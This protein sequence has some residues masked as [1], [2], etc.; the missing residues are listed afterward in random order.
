MRWYWI[1]RYTEFVR[2]ERAT[3]VKNISLAEEHMH[4]HFKYFPVMPHSLVVEGVAQTGGLLISEYKN[5]QEKVVLAKIVKAIF[6]CEAYPGQTL[7]YRVHAEN[8][9]DKG[10]S[11]TAT[12][13]IGDVL[14]AEFE[15]MFAFLDTA[16]W[17]KEL[18]TMREHRH[19]LHSFHVY[20]VG[21]NAD[22]TPLQ[23]PECFLRLDKE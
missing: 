13:H 10:A 5:C 23:E 12:S 7:T 20:E 1:D 4:D 22:G 21:V 16:Q 19:L 9:H 8:I 14:H 6:H 18:F 11:I 2:G 3:A 17:N 15:M